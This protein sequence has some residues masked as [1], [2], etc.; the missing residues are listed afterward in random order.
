M[1][2]VASSRI[3]SSRHFYSPL[4]ESPGY[5]FK[6]PPIPTRLMALRNPRTSPKHHPIPQLF[7]RPAPP[8]HHP[9]TPTPLATAPFEPLTFCEPYR[10][11]SSRPTKSRD[12]RPNGSLYCPLAHK[13]WHPLTKPDR[14]PLDDRLHRRSFFRARPRSILDGSP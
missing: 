6:V 14:R 13:N 8:P 3:K 4:F 1:S 10:I 5:F 12:F 2:Q 7:D 11:E 9:L